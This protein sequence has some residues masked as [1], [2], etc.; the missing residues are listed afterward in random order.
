MTAVATASVSPL[1]SR[2]SPLATRRSCASTCDRTC[3]HLPPHQ[4]SSRVGKGGASEREAAS[5]A[6][7]SGSMAA[8]P[9]TS[10]RPRGVGSKARGPPPPAPAPAPR[11]AAL[12][13]APAA[14][15]AAT[16]IAA[17][18]AATV[19]AAL[20][21]ADELDIPPRLDRLDVAGDRSVGPHA[22]RLHRPNQLRLAQRRRRS[23][24]TLSQNR[25][26]HPQ[27][28]PAPQRR[29]R[30]L[31]RP[32]VRHRLVPPRLLHRQA[33]ARELLAGDAEAR[34]SQP[35]AGGAAEG[36]EE[37]LRHLLAASPPSPGP[38]TTA[39][40]PAAGQRCGAAPSRT[41]A[42]ARRRQ[43]RPARRPSRG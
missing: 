8:H 9:S 17:V 33:A 43:P 24:L 11:R 10:A 19:A 30:H 27:R 42:T 39:A 37:G 7:S 13:L 3:S 41:S 25:H 34:A 5:G 29:Q 1:L 36:G 6:T 21:P 2:A 35:D 18:A 23:G 32:A 28:L 12:A 15:S 20:A 22:R 16:A 14:A 4:P 40:P 31:C 38:P 26:P